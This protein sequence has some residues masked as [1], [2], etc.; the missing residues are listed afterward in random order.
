MSLNAVVADAI[1][2]ERELFE[3]RQAAGRGEASAEGGHSSPRMRLSHRVR[4]RTKAR[5]PEERAERQSA[6]TPITQAIGCEA[7]AL[8]AEV[9]RLGTEDGGGRMDWEGY[10]GWSRGSSAAD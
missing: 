1:D 2:G 6:S 9:G 10:G 5:Q 8:Q 4:L 7:D 3:A